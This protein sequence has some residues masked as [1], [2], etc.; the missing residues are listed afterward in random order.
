VASWLEGVRNERLKP[1]ARTAASSNITR[2]PARPER[3][4]YDLRA[5]GATWLPNI[6][7]RAFEHKPGLWRKMARTY[8]PTPCDFAECSSP[9]DKPEFP[10]L[11]PP[12]I[13]G[14]SLR[15]LRRIAM[16]VGITQLSV[17]SVR[18]WWT[19]LHLA[20]DQSNPRCRR[21]GPTRSAFARS[22]GFPSLRATPHPLMVDSRGSQRLLPPVGDQHCR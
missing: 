1:I 19:G 18:P 10:A 2:S 17:T 20:F 11:L 21:K 15:E 4:V 13:L 14:M 22:P 5:I 8:F 6:V 16:S 7:S 12:G 9:S 3:S